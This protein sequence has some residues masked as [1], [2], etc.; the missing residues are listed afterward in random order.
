[1]WGEQVKKNTFENLLRY[2]EEVSEQVVGHFSSLSLSLSLPV[3][4]YLFFMYANKDFITQ[5]IRGCMTIV[6]VGRKKYYSLLSHSSAHFFALYRLLH[7]VLLT[8]IH[9]LVVS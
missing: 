1:M 3:S 9:I 5:K 6:Y 7:D 4:V 2:Y 8:I